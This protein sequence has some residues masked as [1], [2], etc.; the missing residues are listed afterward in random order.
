M[1][2]GIRINSVI[3]KYSNKYQLKGRM[4]KVVNQKN[5]CLSINNQLYFSL[6]ILLSFFLFSKFTKYSI[7]N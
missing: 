2:L 3:Q 1:G 5:V 6:N 4:S 7:F